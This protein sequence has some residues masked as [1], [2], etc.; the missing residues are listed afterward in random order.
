MPDRDPNGLKWSIKKTAKTLTVGPSIEFWEKHLK[1]E[2]PLGVV[3]IRDDSTCLWGSI[4][5]DKYNIDLLEV[6]ARVEAMKLPLVP[7]RSKSG[8]LHLFIFCSEPVPAGV[9]QLALRNL[10]AVLGFADS[11]IF[12]KQTQ[13]LKDQGDSGNWM[14]MPYFGD[15]FGNK[16]HYQ[17][18]LKKTGAEMTLGEFLTYAEKHK[19]TEA[20]VVEMRQNNVHPEEATKKGKAPRATKPFSD[21]PP[22]LQFMCEAG[23]PEGGRNNAMMHVG[24]YLKKAFPSNWKEK[25]MEHNHKYVTP[26]LPTDEIQQI[27]QQLEKKDYEYLC[28][29]APMSNHCDSV[30]CRT[31]RYG[32]GNDAFPEIAAIRKLLTEP[33]VWFIDVMSSG[34]SITLRLST[35]QLQFFTRFQGACLEHSTIVHRDTPQKLWTAILQEAMEKVELIDAPPDLGPGGRFRELMQTFLTNRTKGTRKEDLLRGAPWED[36][37]EGRYYFTLA[38]LQKYL[39]REGAKDFVKRSEVTHRIRQMHGSED[40]KFNPHVFF[41]IKGHG[42][43]AW[44]VPSGVI[45]K[46]PELDAPEVPREEL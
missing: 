45:E 9:L 35:E 25:L 26:P 32:V 33:A 14:V 37:E 11:E 46:E 27:Q 30:T 40:P 12:P 13:I 15:T 24:I 20:Q 42:V 31:R 5:I 8:G 38:S 34:G 4:D 19:V 21:G 6:I 1:G 18:G 41:N 3:P 10:A 43:N 22:C 7:C 39:E 23:F 16:L 2:R 29:H 44:W 17:Y 28:K 36:E